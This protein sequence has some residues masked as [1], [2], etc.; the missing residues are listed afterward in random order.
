MTL[1]FLIP[2]LANRTTPAGVYRTTPTGVYHT[3]HHTS[4]YAL[5]GLKLVTLTR[6]QP[7]CTVASYNMLQKSIP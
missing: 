6:K 5:N 4:T 2:S 3:I 7:L 1:R